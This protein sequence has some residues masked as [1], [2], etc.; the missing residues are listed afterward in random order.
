MAGK[1][2]WLKDRFPALP[3]DPSYGEALNTQAQQ[4][5]GLPL[6]EVA[7]LHIDL[8]EELS[9]R[10]QEVKDL[11]MRIAAAEEV[12][13]EKMKAEQLESAVI[14]GY[15]WTPTP[16]PYPQIKDR[17]AFRA[18]AGKHMSDN[19]TLHHGTLKSVVK[20]ALEENKPLPDGVEVF[21]KRTFRRTAQ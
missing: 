13:D 7:Q 6:A 16:E 2:A 4:Y 10:Q 12:L 11:N 21:H 3:A 19:L 18:W 17:Q 20:E 14:A 15:R 5:R 1:W 9:E 8:T